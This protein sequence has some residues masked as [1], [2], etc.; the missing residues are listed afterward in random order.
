MARNAHASSVMRWTGWA[1]GT[2]LVLGLPLRSTERRITLQELG[3]R[4]TFDYSAKLNGESVVVR[5]VVSAF[6]YHFSDYNLL[7]FEDR[8]YGGVFKVGLGEFWL[9]RIKLGD[10]IEVV[11][12]VVIQYGMPMVAPENIVVLGH[13]TPPRPADFSPRAARD[14]KYL[15]RLIR[16]EG[17][18][19][20]LPWHNAGGA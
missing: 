12:K 1:L 11:G 7:A 2:C 5:G 6:V 19:A 9:E 16:V 20:D 8:S 10:E 3:S 4:T 18:V 15:G 14:L 13:R 17:M